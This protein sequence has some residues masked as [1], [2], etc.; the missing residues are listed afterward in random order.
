[1]D[2]GTTTQTSQITLGSGARRILAG[3]LLAFVSVIGGVVVSGQQWNCESCNPN[4]ISS[5]YFPSVW[6]EGEIKVCVS[7]AFSAAQKTSMAATV[8]AY[9][10]KG[11]PDNSP[12]PY[13]RPQL[14]RELQPLNAWS[15]SGM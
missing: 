6:V 1:M 11:V 4:R 5:P 12:M 3:F 14:V 7:S 2:T 9:W 13:T 15:T 8:K 10:E